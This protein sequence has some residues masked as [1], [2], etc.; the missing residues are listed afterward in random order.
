[1]SKPA[2]LIVEDE[3]IVAEDLSG[4]IRQLEYEVAGM[5]R[6][7]EEAVG[8]VRRQRPALILMDLRPAGAMDGISAAGFL[9]NT[10][11]GRTAASSKD[12]NC[13]CNRRP[14]PGVWCTVPSRKSYPRM[15]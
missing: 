14:Q 8:F 11:S 1:M 13:R 2:I 6:T 12:G 4:K 3:A 15:A 10:K 5:L 7:G 9:R